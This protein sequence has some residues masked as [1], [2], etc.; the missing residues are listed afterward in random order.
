MLKRPNSMNFG[1]FMCLEQDGPSVL[2]SSATLIYLCSTNA[3]TNIPSLAE[4]P[5]PTFLFP[6]VTFSNLVS[7]SPGAHALPGHGEDSS[8]WAESILALWIHSLW[9]ESGPKDLLGWQDR[10]AF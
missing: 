8:H 7:I 1:T 10:G 6:P 3:L 4:C 2:R 9:A 5:S